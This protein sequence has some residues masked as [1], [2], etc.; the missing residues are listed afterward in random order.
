MAMGMGWGIGLGRLPLNRIERGVE[1]VVESKL[2]RGHIFYL[3]KRHKRL[4]TFVN[5]IKRKEVS[6]DVIRLVFS[7]VVDF[8]KGG[9][10]LKKISN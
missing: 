1:R 5:Q 6:I 9:A 10:Q 7:A 4:Q 3:F 2:D 8:H